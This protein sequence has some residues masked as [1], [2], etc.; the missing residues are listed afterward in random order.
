[1]TV[2]LRCGYELL[3][4]L[5]AFC[6]LFCAS[7]PAFCAGSGLPTNPF[8]LPGQ[9]TRMVLACPASPAGDGFTGC[10]RVHHSSCDKRHF[11]SATL[12]CGHAPDTP[13]GPQSAGRGRHVITALNGLPGGR[14]SFRQHLKYLASERERQDHDRAMTRVAFPRSGVEVGDISRPWAARP[15]DFNTPVNSQLPAA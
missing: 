7:S 15:A 13:T 1:M 5:Q 6:E 14:R 2:Q 11:K 3:L 10:S 8:L 12:A 9:E 4:C